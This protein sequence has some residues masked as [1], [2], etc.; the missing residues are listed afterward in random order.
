[1]CVLDP[2]DWG[3]DLHV[4]GVHPGINAPTDVLNRDVGADGRVPTVLDVDTGIPLVLQNQPLRAIVSLEN[5]A[6]NQE[7]VEVLIPLNF[8]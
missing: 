7:G 8:Y 5:R 3:R 6:R 4:D 1:M 2:R